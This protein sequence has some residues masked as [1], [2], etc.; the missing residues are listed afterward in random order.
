MRTTV[1]RRRV[2]WTVIA[3]LG[4]TLLQPAGAESVAA[5]PAALAIRHHDCEAAVALLNPNAT[6]NDQQTAFIG[7]RMLSEGICVELNPVGTAHF[8]AHA[9]D[10][11]D[12]ASILEFASTVG[13][14]EGS[15]QSYEHAGEVCQGAGLDA[16]KNLSRYTLGYTCTVVGTAGKMLRTAL[17]VGAFVPGS[18]A[19]T[20]VFDA[21][22]GDME[23]VDT[24]GVG[25][26][27]RATGS[28]IAPPLINARREIEKAWKN[29][30]SKVPPPDRSR[31]EDVKLTLNL[32]VDMTLERGLDVVNNDDA[33]R[34]KPFMPGDIPFAKHAP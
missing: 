19:A 33:H 21:A 17:P 7:G 11:G 22:T 3:A 4:A 32:D 20:V 18:G 24:P 15:P 8:Y 12:K 14:G 25:R 26:G 28:H 29:A 6:L 13:R 1:L 5:H 27:E 30:L 23:I 10:L 16:P 31:L 34:F 2:Q 9:A